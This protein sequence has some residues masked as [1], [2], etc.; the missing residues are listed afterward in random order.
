MRPAL[1]CAH[2]CAFSGRSLDRRGANT[3]SLSA[4]AVAP[5]SITVRPITVGPLRSA[6][7]DNLSAEGPPNVLVSRCETL[8]C[9]AVP[10][11]PTCP[12]HLPCPPARLPCL[13]L[14]THSHPRWVRRQ[15]ISVGELLPGEELIVG[16]VI[17]TAVHT[18]CGTL[19]VP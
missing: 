14:V 8:P 9:P 6:S 15:R 19:R 11:P 13:R 5:G 4:I 12:A 2:G 3:S 10:Y 18:T 17:A 16:Q 7:F 1:G